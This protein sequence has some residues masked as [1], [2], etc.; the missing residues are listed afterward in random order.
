MVNPNPPPQAAESPTSNESVAPGEVLLVLAR[1]GVIEVYQTW[2]HVREVWR[3]HEERLTYEDLATGVKGSLTLAGGQ[4]VKLANGGGIREILLRF[5]TQPT[6]MLPPV[7]LSSSPPSTK[8]S[9]FPPTPPLPDWGL[10]YLHC[11]S[12]PGTQPYYIAEFVRSRGTSTRKELARDL[13]SKGYTGRSG[14]IDR[15]I[16]LLRDFTGQIRQNGRG[17]ATVYVWN[18]GAVGGGTSVRAATPD[19]EL[20]SGEIDEST[21]NGSD[22]YTGKPIRGFLLHG[23]TYEVRTAKEMLLKLT[24]EVAGQNPARIEALTTIRGTL[25]QYFSKDPNVIRGVP[26]RV[27]GTSMYAETNLSRDRV[28]WSC[29]QVLRVFGIPAQE[30]EVLTDQG[31]EAGPA[32]SAR[33]AW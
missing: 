11:L 30:F 16:R 29:R 20:A 12:T 5:K 33:P 26:A 3:P 13:R 8:P 25:R 31:E 2:D 28:V 15:T 17:G 32:T 7:V 22:S 1:E 6:A 4:V 23:V 18:Q 10:R 19:P 27:P 14:Q 24:T 21:S 9:P